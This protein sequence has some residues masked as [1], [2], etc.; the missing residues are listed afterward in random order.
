MIRPLCF[1]CGFFLNELKM[2]IK[3]DDTQ[4]N[5]S[6]TLTLKDQSQL[7]GLLRGIYANHH[8]FDVEQLDNCY[9]N[10]V[11][12]VDLLQCHSD[13]FCSCHNKDLNS[14]MA[15]EKK[16]FFQEDFLIFRLENGNRFDL[17]DQILNHLW[18]QLSNDDTTFY[19]LNYQIHFCIICCLRLQ[20]QVIYHYKVVALYLYHL[21]EKLDEVVYVHIFL[22]FHTFLV[23][24]D[25]EAFYCLCNINLLCL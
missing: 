3:I 7:P 12:S 25:I 10:D 6:P 13:I 1:C 24:A 16:D 23:D 2:S 17:E 4:I 15:Q 21:F 11:I 18:L 9:Y 20:G 19:L 22:D 14:I 8:T 5:N